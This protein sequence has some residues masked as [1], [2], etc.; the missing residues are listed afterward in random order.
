MKWKLRR[1]VLATVLCLQFVGAA[2]ADTVTVTVTGTTS[3][4]PSGLFG[5]VGADITV[6]YK[7]DTAL[8]TSSHDALYTEVSVSGGTVH[9][10]VS[11]SLGATVTTQART[12]TFGG[13][14]NAQLFGSNNGIN[15]GSDSESF[16]FAEDS[17]SSYVASDVHSRTTILPASITTPFSYSCQDSGSYVDTCV[18][19]GYYNGLPFTLHE[20]NVTLSAV[21]AVP[22][23][24]AGAGLPGLILA[25]GGLLGW[26]RRRH[27]AAA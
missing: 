6:V 24:I 5:S 1:A 20:A 13:A 4:D 7:F 22:G 26:W 11:P 27:K 17:E 8:G 10:I 15:G 2:S 3:Y 16:Q 18:G 14:Y 12:I 23:P 21:A 19:S 25:G 9:G